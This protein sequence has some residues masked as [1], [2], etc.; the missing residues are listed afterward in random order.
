[1]SGHKS[2]QR[3]SLNGSNPNSSASSIVSFHGSW[4][5]EVRLAEQD[6]CDRKSHNSSGE[7]SGKNAQGDLSNDLNQSQGIKNHEPTVS[8]DR[9]ISLEFIEGVNEAKFERLLK[10]EKLKT[11]FKRRYSQ[12]PSN[13]SRSDST[14]GS[15]SDNEADDCSSNFKRTSN[16][17]KYEDQK[18]LR[19]NSYGCST[20]SK[21]SQV[22]DDPVVLARRQ[23]QIDYGKNTVAYERYLEMVPIRKRNH[24]RTPD[25]YGKYSRRTF[26]GL[27][28]VWRKQLHYYDPEPVAGNAED[29]DDSD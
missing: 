24:P 25:K 17:S 2:P 19:Y 27:I 7:S 13:E 10:E 15:N 6:G 20:S 8:E 26:D 12:T 1:M 23:K 29:N 5:H 4:A 21:E 28:K 14:N 11:P 3:K 9:E 18:R 16:N 22:E